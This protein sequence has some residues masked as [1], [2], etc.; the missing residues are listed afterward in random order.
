VKRGRPPKIKTAQ[1]EIKIKN[2][3][4][5]KEKNDVDSNNLNAKTVTPE[6]VGKYKKKKVETAVINDQNQ[7]VTEQEIYQHEI[8]R[9]VDKKQQVYVVPEEVVG[10]SSSKISKKHSKTKQVKETIELQEPQTVQPVKRGR[11]TKRKAVNH[12]DSNNLATKTVTPE[13]VGKYKKKK[14]E[15]AVTNYQCQ[16]V[17][18]QEMCQ[19]EVGKWLESE[20]QPTNPS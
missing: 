3:D 20:K 16:K 19:S 1:E 11:P 10:S 6:K 8:S 18:H 2:I 7:K 17:V 13:M 9:K 12:D 4:Q 14:C 15:P 5:A